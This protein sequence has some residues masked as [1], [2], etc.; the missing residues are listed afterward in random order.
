VLYG[1][2]C[3]MRWQM[4]AP[5]DDV[6][7]RIFEEGHRWHRRVSAAFAEAGIDYVRQEEPMQ[8]PELQMS[9]RMDGLVL[10]G[11]KVPE[12]APGEKAVIDVKGMS[13]YAFSAINTVRDLL[14]SN[15]WYHRSYLTQSS[16][17]AS[18][19]EV[20][21]EWCCI[22]KIKRSSAETGQIWWRREDAAV[23]VAAAV[24]A[25]RKINAAI[26]QPMTEED[27]SHIP[28]VDLAVPGGWCGDCSYQAICPAFVVDERGLRFASDEVTDMVQRL[29]E[30]KPAYS[31]Y[32]QIQKQLRGMWKIAGPGLYVCGD[33]LADV[34]ETPEKP[35]PAKP[36][37]VRKASLRTTYREK[38]E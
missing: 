32:A 4:Q 37:T 25:C 5:H 33:Y 18:H 8:W 36:A 34:K 27:G 30:L 38:G 14:E 9:G 22:Y 35:V 29:H 17:Y 24:D 16:V 19:S 26:D 3:R 28:P 1:W 10:A 12:M 15:H 2:F 13:D 7:L 23:E 20:M 31:E 11:P 6:L 21:A